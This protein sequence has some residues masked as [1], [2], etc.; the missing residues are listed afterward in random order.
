[1]DKARRSERPSDR[2]GEGAREG[3]G[4]VAPGGAAIAA[5]TVD[6]LFAARIR[7]AAAEA[8][9]V[10]G[11]AKLL[12]TVGAATRLVLVDLQ[13]RDAVE[14]VARVRGRAPAARVVAFAPHVAEDLLA[15]GRSAGADRV[16]TRGAFVRELPQLVRYEAG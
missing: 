3:E 15:A 14:A 16:M 5:L 13:A 12:D 6:L 11:L 10:Q 1:M 9:A 7:G 2:P 8:V 4:A